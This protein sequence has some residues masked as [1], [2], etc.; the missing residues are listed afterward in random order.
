MNDFL[1]SLY[2]YKYTCITRI[3]RISNNNKKKS[4]DNVLYHINLS[5]I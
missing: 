3:T 1:K 5:M 4:Y 2:P